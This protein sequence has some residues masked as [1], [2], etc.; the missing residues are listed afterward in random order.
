MENQLKVQ[1][2]NPWYDDSIL[3][4]THWL[5]CGHRDTCYLDRPLGVVGPEIFSG[6]ILP[7]FA[8]FPSWLSRGWRDW[9]LSVIKAFLFEWRS[10]LF[11][12]RPTDPWSLIGGSDLGTSPTQEAFHLWESAIFINRLSG[13]H[14]YPHIATHP[15]IRTV[16]R[17]IPSLS[18]SGRKSESTYLRR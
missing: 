1:T 15:H 12:K 13:H 6:Y 17:Y 14:R 10:V 11:S 4:I 8:S 5:I 9:I 3:N 16:D 7:Y 18:Y 2:F